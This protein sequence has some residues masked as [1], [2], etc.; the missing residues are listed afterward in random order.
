M[1]NCDRVYGQR[2]IMQEFANHLALLGAYMAYCF[3]LYTDGTY[4]MVSHDGDEENS[5]VTWIAFLV[6]WMLAVAFLYRELRQCGLYISN[7]G[8]HGFFCWLSSAWNWME[9]LSYLVIVILIPLSEFIFLKAGRKSITLSSIVALEALLL[10]SRVL[11]YPRTVPVIGKFVTVISSVASAIV[12]FLLIA[13]CVMFGFAIAFHVL[14]RHT[15]ATMME[16]EENSND[17]D[18][19]NL[20]RS[21]GTFGRTMFTVFGFTFG[22]FDLHQIYHAPSGCTVAIV[23]VLYMLIVSTTLLNMLIAVMTNEFNG[24]RDREGIR[25]IHA[26][27]MA[28]DDIDCMMSYAQRMKLK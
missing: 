26:R 24:I 1:T 11:Y 25:L 15:V 18:L 12:P 19:E 16:E 21:F 3:T 5:N 4:K 22:E 23:F 20:R 14:Y 8:Y 9:V 27:A 6:C 13:L 7:N 28:L 17:G 2:L 10:W